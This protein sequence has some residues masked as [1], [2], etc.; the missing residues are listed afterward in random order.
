[1]TQHECSTMSVDL[2]RVSMRFHVSDRFPSGL[3]G[4]TGSGIWIFFEDGVSAEQPFAEQLAAPTVDAGESVIFFE[5]LVLAWLPA[6]PCAAL[7]ARPAS[8]EVWSCPS[9]VATPSACFIACVAAIIGA[10]E[11]NFVTVG[12]LVSLRVYAPDS[13]LCL[14]QSPM[15]L[16]F[17]VF[18]APRSFGRDRRCTRAAFV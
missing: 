17:L 16:R 11:G 15:G 4:F 13:S 1:M 2:V 9:H 6:A 7:A 12:L 8:S 3:L 10:T 14:S 5:G 18:A